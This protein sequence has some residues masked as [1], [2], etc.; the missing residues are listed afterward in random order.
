MD[1]QQVQDLYGGFASGD[2]GGGILSML[3]RPKRPVYKLAPEVDQNKALATMGAFGQNAAITQGNAIA[4]Q[5]AAQDVNTAQQYASSTGGILNTLK[6]INANR[7]RTKQG[8]AIQDADM[9]AQGREGLINTNK[10]V[11][12]ELD[13]A[14]NYNVNEPYQNMTKQHTDATKTMQENFWKILDTVGGMAKLGGM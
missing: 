11:I 8:L 3:T 14:W 4:D 1:D 13:K 10:D 12:D 9:R 7:N 6:S 5:T 2:I